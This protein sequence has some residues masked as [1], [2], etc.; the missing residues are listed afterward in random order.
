MASGSALTLDIL[1]TWPIPNYVN[2]VSQQ[3]SIE[4]ALLTTTIVMIIFVTARVYVRLNQ[5]SGIGEDD[6]VMVIAGARLPFQPIRTALTCLGNIHSP[7]SR[8][9]DSGEI[10][11][12]TPPL[13]RPNR[14]SCSVCESMWPYFHRAIHALTPYR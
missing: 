8:P 12:R 3:T 13:R 4:A 6:W 14:I 1:A 5:K 7:H 2:P 11:C 10:C 9:L